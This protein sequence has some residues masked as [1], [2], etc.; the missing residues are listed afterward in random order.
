[1]WGLKASPH[2]VTSSE[3][4]PS[5]SLQL[6]AAP[7]TSSL[8][9]GV[10]KHTGLLEFLGSMHH[11]RKF[12]CLLY[13]GLLLLLLSRVQLFATPRTAAR[14]APL[15]STASWSLLKLTSRESVLTC[16]RIIHPLS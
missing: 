14:Q 5:S 7:S 11:H 3:G 6:E 12:S 2:P 9:P 8:P 13:A 16:L 15:S 4:R 10:P 1:M